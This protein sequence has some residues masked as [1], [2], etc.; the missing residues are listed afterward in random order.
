MAGAGALVL[1]AMLLA[2]LTPIIYVADS[3][4]ITTASYYLSPAFPP[5]YPL[6]ISIDKLFT[7]LPAGSIAYRTNLADAVPACVAFALVFWLARGFGANKMLA[8]SAATLSALL[9]L[10][11]SQSL[12]AEVFTLNSVFCLLVL[13]LGLR[14]LEDGDARYLYACAFL[15]GL[16]TGNHHTLALLLLPIAYPA[17]KLG[18]KRPAL[19]FYCFIF[20]SAGFMINLLIVLRSFAVKNSAFIYGVAFNPS[21][22]LDIFFRKA[23]STNTLQSLQLLGGGGATGIFIWLQ[24]FVNL[25]KYVIAYN[26][27]PVISWLVLASILFLPFI[28]DK[29]AWYLLLAAVPWLFILPRMTFTGTIQTERNVDIVRRYY[30]P[31]LYILCVILSFQAYRVY[32]LV[33][34]TGLRTVKLAG[35]LLL[36]PL[37][38]LPSLP[39][40]SVSNDY[41]AYDRARDS[42]SAMPPESI[43]LLYGDNV[44][45]GTYYAQWIEGYRQ[46]ILTLTKNPLTGN[47]DIYGRSSIY[48]NGNIFSFFKLRKGLPL[49]FPLSYLDSEVV[50]GKFFVPLDKALPEFL[51]K[52][53]KLTKFGSLSYRATFNG[54]PSAVQ[55]DDFIAGNVD[56]L[57]Y[58]RSV[59]APGGTFLADE[60]K[61]LY[62]FSLLT[63]LSIK[64]P[65]PGTVSMGAAALRLVNPENF[66]PYFVN[67]LVKSSSGDPLVFLKW[68]EQNMP[69]TKMAE[70]AH[71]LE[72]VMLSEMGSKE[73]AVKYDYLVKNGLLIYL[74]NVKEIYDTAM[75]DAGVTIHI[76]S[77]ASSGT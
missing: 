47:L 76:A 28:K 20:L 31:L 24:G 50:K 33:K 48:L 75:K 23:Y 26:F 19:F 55:T 62:G 54:Q 14:A 53:Y 77:S 13:Y 6:P 11:F 61:N 56:K 30:V 35:A 4:L 22:F 42:L 38:Y 59:G 7:F 2:S 65:G 44:A 1:Y 41:L 51:K 71:V 57:N 72:Y 29:R 64:G 17:I 58:E 5:G 68:T 37:F 46:D 66:L 21:E 16:G 52:R 70:M 69:Y 10:A 25:F 3:A 8:L 9:P 60:I 12:I 39:G 67:L 36:V 45:F 27:G 40:L 63:A 18:R 34:K 32:F 74:D 73:A 15:F 43:F 49:S